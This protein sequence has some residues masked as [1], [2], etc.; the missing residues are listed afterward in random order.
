MKNK[1]LS[2]L[3]KAYIKFLETVFSK[4]FIVFI[5]ATFL[6]YKQFITE[7]EWLGIATSYLGITGYLDNK[8]QNNVFEI[9]E[10]TEPGENVVTSLPSKSK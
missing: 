8:K 10:I 7:L 9:E 1:L 4:K 3:Y 6:R 5:L 2:P